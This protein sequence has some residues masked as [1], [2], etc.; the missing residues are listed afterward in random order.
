MEIRQLEMCDM[1]SI[2]LENTQSGI[3]SF[4]SKR[5]HGRFCDGL[6]NNIMVL[7]VGPIGTLNDRIIAREY[8][9]RLDN[10][11]NLVIQRLFPNNDVVFQ[12]NSAETVQLWLEEHEDDHLPW[13]AQSPHLSI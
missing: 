5:R 2:R 13:P 6:G 12:G 3:P 1:I 8:V 9:N 7:L 4:S 10:D 11:V